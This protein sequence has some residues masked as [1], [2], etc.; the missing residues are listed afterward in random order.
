MNCGPNRQEEWTHTRLQLSWSLPLNYLINVALQTCARCII[1]NGRSAKLKDK[2]ISYQPSS[3]GALNPE[4]DT[5]TAECCPFSVI[6]ELLAWPLSAVRVR[7]CCTDQSHSIIILTFV[8][9]FKS[10][11]WLTFLN[12]I[13]ECTRAWATS[14]LN[15]TKT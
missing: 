14:D 2:G 12:F 10:I 6:T 5:C 3:E 11:L 4:L 15:T 8:C 9:S 7:V 13:N 1:N